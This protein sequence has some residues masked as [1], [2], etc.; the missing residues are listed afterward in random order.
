MPEELK[1][2]TKQGKSEDPER[3][4]IKTHHLH[5]DHKTSKKYRAF[6]VS[7]FCFFAYSMPYMY[8]VPN[9]DWKVIAVGAA[10]FCLN[11]LAYVFCQTPSDIALILKSVNHKD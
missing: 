6:I 10:F 1:N 7:I 3:A 4:G 5:K 11:L 8:M 9:P 2:M